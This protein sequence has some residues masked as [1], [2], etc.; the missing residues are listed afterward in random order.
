MK[1][2]LLAELNEFEI[3][4]ELE[5]MKQIVVIYCLKQY[6]GIKE[7]SELIWIK[8]KINLNISNI[9]YWHNIELMWLGR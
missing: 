5:I 2:V 1:L 3:I 6:V 7:Q 9:G 4:L 8:W